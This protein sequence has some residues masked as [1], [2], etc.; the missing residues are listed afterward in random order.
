MFFSFFKEIAD[1]RC[2]SIL[3][4]P[5]RTLFIF[6]NSQRI[7]FYTHFHQFPPY[8]YVYSAESIFIFHLSQLATFPRDVLCCLIHFSSK[9]E[10]LFVYFCLFD[11]AAFLSGCNGKKILQFSLCLLVHIVFFI[12]AIFRILLNIFVNLS[13]FTFFD[14]SYFFY[15]LLY[16]FK[17]DVSISFSIIS[18]RSIVGTYLFLC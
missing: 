13:F 7:T 6:L 12:P 10:L 1:I 4:L 8:Y 18:V 17:D 11:P 5:G 16:R 2:F 14:I 15:Q 9:M 3:F